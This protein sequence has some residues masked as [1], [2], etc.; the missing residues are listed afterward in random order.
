MT[1]RKKQSP[2]RIHLQLCFNA[3]FQHPELEER[4]HALNA[5]M[6]DH[7]IRERLRRLLPALPIPTE[8]A[9]GTPLHGLDGLPP[10]DPDPANPCHRS[11]RIEFLA[12][13]SHYGA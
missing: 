9:N 8:P 3:W 12:D 1:A 5:A 7:E 2:E 11:T 13:A 4:H 10:T 6:K